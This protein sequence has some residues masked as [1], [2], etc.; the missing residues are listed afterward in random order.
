MDSTT[1]ERGADAVR[2]PETVC[3]SGTRDVARDEPTDVTC[4]WYWFGGGVKLRAV[5]TLYKIAFVRPDGMPSS[6]PS[7]VDGALGPGV[8]IATGAAHVDALRGLADI[9]T[10]RKATKQWREIR[11]A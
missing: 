9:G 10:G 5:G 11:P 4:P 3:W 1:T 7:L 2:R 6:D 8:T